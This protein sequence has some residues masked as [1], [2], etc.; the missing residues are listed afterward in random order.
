MRTI[1]EK[2]RKDAHVETTLMHVVQI[3]DRG[4]SD[5]KRSTSAEAIEGSGHED[6]GPRCAVS[7]NDIRNRPKKITQQVDRSTPI[8]V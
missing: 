2:H 5:S 3:A 6:S 8:D 1:G 7:G 4:C